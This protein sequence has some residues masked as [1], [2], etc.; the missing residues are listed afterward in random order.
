MSFSGTV[1]CLAALGSA[2]AWAYSSSLFRK[3]GEE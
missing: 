1:G 2:A 3:I